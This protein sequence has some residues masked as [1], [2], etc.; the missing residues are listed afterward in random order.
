MAPSPSG[1]LYIEYNELREKTRELFSQFELNKATETTTITL[2]K[3]VNDECDGYCGR[4]EAYC[5]TDHYH[6]HHHHHYHQQSMLFTARALAE[7]PPIEFTD[8]YFINIEELFE[9]YK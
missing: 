5:P 4:T 1:L 8:I 6:H 7:Y 2:N 3:H 9:W